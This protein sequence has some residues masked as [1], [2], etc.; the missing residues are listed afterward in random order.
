MSKTR[1]YYYES[2]VDIAINQ[3][4]KHI[5]SFKMIDMF[6]NKTHIEMVTKIILR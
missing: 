5:K 6:P 2:V 1:E 3:A 4:L